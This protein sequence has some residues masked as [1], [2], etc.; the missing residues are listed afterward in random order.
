MSEVKKERL[1]AVANDLNNSLQLDPKIKFTSKSTFAYLKKEIEDVANE[2]LKDGDT[3]D[4]ATVDTL[5]ALEVDVPGKIKIRKTGT[6]KPAAKGAAKPATKKAAKKPGEM[7]N[8]SKCYLE[9]KKN[10]KV[11]PEQLVKVAKNEVKL[12]SVKIW[13]RMWKKGDKN[14]LPAI[15]TKK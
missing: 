2:L 1:E 3:L 6:A 9:W 12:V 11:T 10:P 14:W 4:K 15:A 5:L 13:I 8:K 7:S